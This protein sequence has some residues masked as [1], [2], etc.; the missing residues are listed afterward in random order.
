[1]NS[2]I[3]RRSFIKGSA[4]LGAGL[5]IGFHIQPKSV[6]AQAPAPASY[7]PN[8]FVRIGTDSSVTVVSKHTEMGQGIYTGLATILAEEL[9][10][11]WSQVRTEAAPVDAQVYAHLML[12]VQGT[13]GS[14]SIPNAWMQYRQVGATARAMLVQAAAAAWSVPAAEI[15]V[16]KGVLSHA[17][18]KRGSF[19]EFATAA[20]ALPAPQNVPLKNPQDFALIGTRLP[21]VDTRAKVTGQAMYTID[22]QRPGMLTAVV[23]HA[24]KFGAT[25]ESFDASETLKVPGVVEV[26]QIPRGVAVL[27]QN[28]WAAIRGRQVL[29][30]QWDESAA[31]QRGTDEI[32]ADFT[33]LLAQPGAAVQDEGDSA[34]ALASAAQTFEATY[35]FPFLAHACMEPVDCSLEFDGERAVLRSGTQMQSVEQQRV[36]ETLG[37]PLENVSIETLYAG[38]GFG[39]RGNFVPDLEVETAS[40]VKATGGKY[41]VKLIY[42]REDDM[43]AGYY[44]PL[45]VH[46]LRAGL[47]G[48]GNITAWENRLA[49][50][51]FADGTMFSFL[52]QNGVDQLA[53]EGASELP[54]HV[55]NMKVDFHMARSGVPTLAW[56]S[57]GHTHTAFSK[58]TFLDELLS[59]AGKDP[60]EGRLALMQDERGKAVI[61]AAAEKY[62]W[63]KQLPAGRA[64][65]FAY[66]ESFGGRVAQI[67][68]VSQDSAGRIK[69]EHVTCAVD[70]G[71]AINP[72]IIEAQVESAIMFGMS[73][74]LYGDIRME[75]GKVVTSNFHN[76]PVV[77][78]HQAPQIDVV[79]M[80]STVDPTG[81]GE[82]ATPV[83]GP[84]IANAWAKL[85]GQ[86]VRRLP[87]E[88]AELS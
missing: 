50:Q 53:I 72:H 51:S 31:E 2:R 36:A 54:Y 8:A 66:T 56:R 78:M 7:P 24:P 4:S 35:V 3:D 79:I 45:F 15:G 25:L 84:A 1:M 83:I 17:S 77:R 87:F 41:P 27:A 6:L 65:G 11:D 81:I 73:A 86:R 76:Y 32:I 13:G 22:V 69:V 23:A 40:I 52:V 85:T 34:A 70:C 44:R 80:P 18:G 21:K 39:R 20:A 5:V 71:M 64:A 68:E 16:S 49:G 59:A 29:V 42:T 67:A 47:D 19:G 75:Q 38:G 10:A 58:E 57:V 43:A 37:I 28:T 82:P 46:R 63:G 9:D 12:G 62:G 88:Q 14:M 30:T 33:A 60:V 26:V 55:P 61:R 74:A 48:D